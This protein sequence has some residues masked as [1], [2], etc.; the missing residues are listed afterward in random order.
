MRHEHP[1]LVLTRP[2]LETIRTNAQT[3][4]GRAM[5]ARLRELLAREPRA[6]DIGFHAAG[7]GLLHILGDSGADHEA[8]LAR[9][10]VERTLSDALTHETAGPLWTSR[11]KMIIRSDPAVGVAFAYDLCHDA[12]DPAFREK[13]AA[14]LDA[15]AQELIRGGGQGWNG[16]PASNWHANTRSAA[17]ICA[18]SV[19][20]DPGAPQ[21]EAS[22]RAAVNGVRAYFETVS[23]DRGWTQE[24]FA[25]YRYPLTHHLLPFLQCHRSV[26]SA[27]AFAGTPA[28][29][30]ALFDVQLLVPEPRFGH[31]P[32]VNGYP[33]WENNHY[34]S[35]DFAMGMGS[36]PP[37][38]RPALHW[39]WERWFG[40]DGDRTFDIGLPHHALFALANY[41]FETPSAN[42]ATVLDRFW[43]D[44]KKG[45][46]IF[47]D[48]WEGRDDFVAVF[49][50]NV[51]PVAGTGR[52]ECAGG[53]RI[54]GLGARWVT[55]GF[56]DGR[57]GENVVQ[58]EGV[59]PKEGGRLVHAHG[60]HDGSG[61]VVVD[62][63][64]VYG[65]AARRHFSVDYSGRSGAAAL[66]TITD[67]IP[68]GRPGTW[69]LHT[70]E[71]VEVRA[72]TFTL[73]AADG[74]VARGTLLEPA[75]ATFVTEEG[76][77]SFQGASGEGEEHPLIRRIKAVGEGRFRI[78][79]T[80]DRA[81]IPEVGT[82]DGSRV[83]VGGQTVNFDTPAP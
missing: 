76:H 21:A 26:M 51:A 55:A 18:L 46:F 54:F 24:S 2:T 4:E 81:N 66:F 71:R 19:L 69:S 64:A 33:L 65:G 15:K 37:A 17:G 23:G 8:A 34:R 20:G 44:R 53:F 5:V 38:K 60:G 78:V 77:G 3:P 47:R 57:A 13:V 11:Y 6:I 31:V 67:E 74:A 75:R 28:D 29:W 30:L 58:T 50:M 10:L 27:N 83:Q 35:G 56:E 48:R 43:A 12:W 32:I 68:A 7:H 80:I 79:L 70:F 45:L 52:P 41:P 61:T 42:P 16:S 14:A 22:L 1:R 73:R 72:N 49:D 59:R 39:L 63:S 9:T 36:V 62:L 25:Y 40:M 82:P